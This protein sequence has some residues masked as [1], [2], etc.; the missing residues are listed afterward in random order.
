MNKSRRSVST[1]G[2]TS[3]HT[4]VNPKESRR[5]SL[6]NGKSHKKK[7]TGPSRSQT[8]QGTQSSSCTSSSTDDKQMEVDNPILKLFDIRSRLGK[9]VSLYTFHP[10]YYN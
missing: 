7:S 2:F 8:T 5:S 4:L 6:G 10:Y 9:G 3:S 1:E